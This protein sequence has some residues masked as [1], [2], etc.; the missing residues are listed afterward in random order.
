M[1]VWS[2]G[3]YSWSLCEHILSNNNRYSHITPHPAHL[4][5]HATPLTCPCRFITVTE[6]LLLHTAKWSGVFGSM[7]TELTVTSVSEPDSDALKVLTHSVV[8]R[9]HICE[10]REK[11]LN[12]TVL[13]NM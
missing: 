1:V 7:W 6:L 10:G 4:T 12:F 2:H 9:L 5:L 13:G 8:F 3:Q 11:A